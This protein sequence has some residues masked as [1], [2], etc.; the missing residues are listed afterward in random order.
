MARKI[1]EA[2]PDMGIATLS[3]FAFSSDN[4]QRPATEV[5]ALFQ[6]LRMY[7]HRET[8]RAIEEGVRFHIIGRR[9][10]MPAGLVRA[11]VEAEQA[12]ARGDVLD[13]RLC[14]DYSG[15]DAILAAARTLRERPDLEIN[16]ETFSRLVA[17]DD[18]GSARPTPEVD[19]LIR[20]G[21]EWRVSDFLLWECAY[22]ELY[23]TSR[24]WPEFG[25]S[26]LESAV[27]EFNRRERRFGR[28]PSDG[29]AV[30]AE[31]ALSPRTASPR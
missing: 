18:P 29:A 4:W 11:I 31:L 21:G 12:T 6:L 16:R 13:L 24:M 27:L 22:A 15:R 1:V 14:L 30:G 20:T 3:L 7:L 19:L 28:I 23:F 2:A 8:P 10:R 5:R 25:P 17:Q 26:E 9:D